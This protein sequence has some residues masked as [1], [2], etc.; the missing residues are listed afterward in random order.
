MRVDINRRKIEWERLH[1]KLQFLVNES[2]S[3]SA[4]SQPREHFLFHQM[5]SDLFRGR[6]EFPL[7]SVACTVAQTQER[8]FNLK[9]PLP[10]VTEFSEARLT[11][12]STILTALRQFSNMATRN[13]QKLSCLEPET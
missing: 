13:G 1:L 8:A 4:P 3:F 7:M 10:S 12:C 2:A 11:V 6:T 9:V 5:A